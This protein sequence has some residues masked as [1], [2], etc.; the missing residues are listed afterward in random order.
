MQHYLNYY[1]LQQQINFLQTIIAVSGFQ[2]YQEIC[3]KFNVVNVLYI[4][5]I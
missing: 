5:I 2:K 3:I 4:F 1:E